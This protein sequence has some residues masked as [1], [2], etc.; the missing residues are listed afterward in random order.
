MIALDSQ[1]RA[2]D[3]ARVAHFHRNGASAERI[4]AVVAQ[5]TDYLT[6]KCHWCFSWCIVS[7]I[8]GD[9]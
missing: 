1:K 7:K 4:G 3:D 9:G 2:R 6:G 5:R 8:V